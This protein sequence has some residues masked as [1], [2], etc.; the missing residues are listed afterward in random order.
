[1]EENWRA[2]TAKRRRQPSNGRSWSSGELAAH[3]NIFQAGRWTG[4]AKQAAVHLWFKE[5]TDCNADI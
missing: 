2:E 3:N 1:M 5:P 4:E